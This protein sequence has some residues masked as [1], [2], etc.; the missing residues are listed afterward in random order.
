LQVGDIILSYDG[1][2]IERSADLPLLVANSSPGK[3]APMEVWRKRETKRLTV[4]PVEG[5][6]SKVAANEPAATGGRLG[7]AVRPLSPEEKGQVNGRAGLVVERVGGA[8]ERAGVQPGDVVLSLNGT[9]VQSVEQLRELV[10]RSGKNVA[11][12]IQREDRQHFVPIE[13][14]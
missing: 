2:P 8:A 7:L 4:A 6:Q 11:L 13:L 1:K 12:L 5:Q 9:P 10:A 3:Q 14:G